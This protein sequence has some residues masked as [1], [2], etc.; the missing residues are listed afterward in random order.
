MYYVYILKSQKDD[1]FYIGSTNNIT[2]RL[3]RHNNK[4]VA[5]TKSR[6]PFEL[7]YIETFSTRKEA[8]NR[9]TQ[10]KKYKSHKFIEKLIS[11][12]KV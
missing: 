3:V 11:K 12:E 4:R 7:V 1:N 2:D 8:I 5:A 10:L 9:E 6:T